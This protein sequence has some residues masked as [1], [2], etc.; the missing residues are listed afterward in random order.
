MIYIYIEKVKYVD[1]IYVIKKPNENKYLKT[2]LHIIGKIINRMLKGFSPIIIVCGGQRMGKSFVAIW[3][4]NIIMNF[5]HD[6]D[7]DIENNVFYDPIES[8]KRIGETDRQ[9]ILID[10]A[11]TYLHKTEWY[12]RVVK[13]MDR[14]IQTQGYKSNCY[15]F[16]SP[17]GSDIAKTF[18][19][20]FDFQLYVRKKGVVITRQIPKK[21]DAFKEIE[22]KL[23]RL[24]QIRIP[25]SAVPKE[26]WEKYEKFSFKQ[27]EEIREL[28]YNRAMY[29]KKDIFGRVGVI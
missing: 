13:A 10:E 28:F 19:K 21:Y 2:N 18:R 3:L 7:F 6:K 11:G 24:E 12:N 23:F 4:S 25:K 26:L 17:F 20:H 9:P 29:R 15:I 1:W 27:K 5:F 8:V 16:V 22:I 14:I